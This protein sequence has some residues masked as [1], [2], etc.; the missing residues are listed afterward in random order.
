MSREITGYYILGY[1]TNGKTFRPSDWLERIASVYG[2]F[3]SNNH[4]RYNPMIKPAYYEGERCLFIDGR[5]LESNPEA[6]KFIMDFARNNALQ[7]HNKGLSKAEEYG[8]VDF[9]EVA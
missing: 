6:Y 9:Q 5:L 2:T 4:L 1:T 8:N 3:E 7:I